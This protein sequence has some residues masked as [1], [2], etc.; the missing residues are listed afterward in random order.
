MA[1]KKD[2]DTKVSTPITLD[3]TRV[4]GEGE[5]VRGGG[6]VLDGTERVRATKKGDLRVP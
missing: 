3:L 5:Q 4:E 2:G 1:P 6:G